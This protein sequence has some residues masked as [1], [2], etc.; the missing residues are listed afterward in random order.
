MPGTPVFVEFQFRFVFQLRLCALSHPGNIQ[1]AQIVSE[2]RLLAQAIGRVYKVDVP[3]EIQ[4]TNV[5]IPGS[6]PFLFA[7]SLGEENSCIRAGRA[8]GLR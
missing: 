3:R 7:S 4:Y 5:I 2:A 8:G 6:Y 1:V